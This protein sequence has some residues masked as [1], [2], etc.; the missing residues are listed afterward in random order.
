MIGASVLDD[1]A[2]ALQLERQRERRRIDDTFVRAGHKPE[3]TGCDHRQYNFE[4][5]GC[6]CPCGTVM[7]D[8]G[9]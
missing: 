4:K 8:F 5:H 1:S 7:V 3:N 2:L 9:N 6:Y